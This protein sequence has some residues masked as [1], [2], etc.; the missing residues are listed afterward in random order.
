MRMRQLTGRVMRQVVRS[1]V[2]VRQDGSTLKRCGGDAVVSETPPN[3]AISCRECPIDVPPGPAKSKRDV[4][5]DRVVQTWRAL[6]DR[7]LLFGHCRELLVV[8]C[9]SCQCGLGS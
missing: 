3:H 4:A 6:I 1:V 5:G 2:E 7:S 9:D 8:N